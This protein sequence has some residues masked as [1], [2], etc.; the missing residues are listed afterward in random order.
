MF[1]HT[2]VW[3]W[4]E[5]NIH[6]T[7][8]YPIWTHNSPLCLLETSPSSLL[9]VN[10]YKPPTHHHHPPL[11]FF[12]CPLLSLVFVI[13]LNPIGISL[14]L[15]TP[16]SIS[17]STL[18]L[19]SATHNVLLSFSLS[20]HYQNYFGK[21]I[22]GSCSPTSFKTNLIICFYLLCIFLNY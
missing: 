13:Y 10:T 11:L 12:L 17:H 9:K 5:Q 16:F 19:F 18:I 20:F 2:V 6:Y 8:P 14:P 22:L 21:G 3:T 1:I 15:L 7:P 4:L